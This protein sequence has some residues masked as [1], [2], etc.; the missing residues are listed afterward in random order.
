MARSATVSI[1]LTAKNLT[2]AVFGEVSSGLGKIKGAVTSM[3]GQLA[4]L[5]LALSSAGLLKWL[6]DV[7]SEYGRLLTQ[8]QTFDGM[9]AARGVFNDLAKFAAETP[10]QIEEV[11]QAYVTLRS[12]GIQPTM[13]S[14]KR[15]GDQSSA[16]GRRIQDF[17]I[18]LRAATTGEFEPMKS[19]GVQMHV[20]GDKA[21]AT[22]Q[23]VTT[24]I[25]RDA[26]SITNYLEGISK[27][28]FAGGM[29]RESKTLGGAL[30]NMKDAADSLG[31]AIGDAGLTSDVTSLTQRMTEFLG[32]ASSI[33][34]LTVDY[35][36][37]KG[38]LLTIFDALALV[39]HAVLMPFAVAGNLV[40]GLVQLVSGF[41][42]SVLVPVAAMADAVSGGKTNFT[43]SLA[44]FAGSSFSGAGKSGK[45]AVD[46]FVSLGNDIGER[47]ANASLRQEELDAAKARRDAIAKN[48]GGSSASGGLKKTG[49]AGAS[50]G[51]AGG[52][53]DEQKKAIEALKDR[54]AIEREF[55]DLKEKEGQHGYELARLE[56]DA[57]KL[58]AKGNLTL[59]ERLDLL[60]A[61]SQSKDARA[62]LGALAMTAE[63]RAKLFKTL[64]PGQ[65]GDNLAP[66]NL[67]IPQAK[68]AN[69]PAA[70]VSF[71]QS[72]GSSLKEALSD[73]EQLDNLI[74]NMA[75]H[76]FLEFG[77]A[78]EDAFAAM[79]DGSISAG[80]AFESAMLGAVA[81]VASAFGQFLMGKATFAFAEGLM[82]DPRGFVAAGEYT[83]AA[84]AMFALS[85]VLKGS[86]HRATGG[87]GR[88]AA[89][90]TSASLSSASDKGNATLVIEGGFL[91]MNDPRQADRLA[92]A[93]ST[94]SDRRVT[95]KGR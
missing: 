87:G 95:I 27:A 47:F 20:N 79:T 69:L 55:I 92:N 80:A 61:I 9:N 91:D 23:G 2:K 34:E 45:G 81:S 40:K 71:A 36:R 26:R 56:E 64:K 11:V 73:G 37:F 76:T 49:L 6:V 43:G 39:T 82:G 72:V 75:S 94:L 38:V 15:F 54:M 67:P 53:V 16:M 84:T 42:S 18:A 48:T 65:I 66:G 57:R 1:I 51:S 88:G 70:Q 25:G 59:Q 10:F 19:F 77:S 62:A 90:A 58:L 30:S 83:A 21:V 13:E 52:F 24:Q 50:S 31:R 22:F 8:L 12:A 46:A 63:E 60:R 93:L 4:G 14:M 3:Q 78:I 33:A 41:V 7:N 74:A 35:L 32:K 85:G 17:A 89:S 44:G 5:G 28:H 86:A 68:A 29:E